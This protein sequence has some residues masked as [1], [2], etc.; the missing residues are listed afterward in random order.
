VK[1]KKK[2]VVFMFLGFLLS[3]SCFSEIYHKVILSGNGKILICTGTDNDPQIRTLT[4]CPV[5]ATGCATVN[6]TS[7][8][9]GKLTEYLLAFLN[10]CNSSGITNF[11]VDAG[12]KYAFI[13]ED[14]SNHR[15]LKMLRF[16]FTEGTG[17]DIEITMQSGRVGII[18]LPDPATWDEMR[19]IDYMVSVL[20]EATKS[21]EPIGNQP[22]IC[23]TADRNGGI[24][25]DL[26][27]TRGS[28]IDC[29]AIPTP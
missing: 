3:K 27:M 15:W 9:Q 24:I 20:F 29:A 5:G 18:R 21:E 13:V 17:T 6:I 2:F 16:S 4:D 11:R 22:Y 12:P 26:Y 19:K 8:K 14:N 10:T 25:T 1:T 7:G 23:F 28:A